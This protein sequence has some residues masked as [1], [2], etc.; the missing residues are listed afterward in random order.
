MSIS[1]SSIIYCDNSFC[2]NDK[3]RYFVANNILFKYYF[4]VSLKYLHHKLH[5]NKVFRILRDKRLYYFIL[6]DYLSVIYIR[7]AKIMF[8]NN[9]AMMR[10]FKNKFSGEI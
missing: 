6:Q 10:R 4:E 9:Y 3:K 7:N 2:R 8:V 1:E 5:F